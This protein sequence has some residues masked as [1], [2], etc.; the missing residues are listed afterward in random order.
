MCLF[1][2]MRLDYA[3]L[4]W[5]AQSSAC[6]RHAVLPG[7]TIV[8]GENVTIGANVDRGMMNTVLLLRSGRRLA[9]EESRSDSL[10]G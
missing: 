9:C 5:D 2:W 4:S 3:H 7:K 10:P 6:E 1:K 8:T